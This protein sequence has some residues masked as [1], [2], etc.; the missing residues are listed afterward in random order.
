MKIYVAF[1][2]DAWNTYNSARLLFVGTSVSKL[3]RVI[4]N[5][6][7]NANIEYN[8]DS[9]KPLVQAKTFRRDMRDRKSLWKDH[10]ETLLSY[11]N[12]RLKYAFIECYDN[13]SEC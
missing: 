3:T 4:S 12:P 6:I 9:T 2:C 10:P 13:N 11:I 8:N 1:T 7:E 5:E